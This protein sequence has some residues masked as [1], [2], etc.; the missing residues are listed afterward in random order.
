[1]SDHP[2]VVVSE[3]NSAHPS[4]P[5][6]AVPMSETSLSS[7]A[8][9]VLAGP[10]ET[11]LSI[12][13]ALDEVLVLDKRIEKKTQEATFLAMFS[14]KN[15]Q[16]LVPNQFQHAAQADWQC[17]QDLIHRRNAIKSAIL[18]SNAN[19]Y[20][21]VAGER[22]T[23][24]EVIERKKSLIL[25]VQLLARMKS[26]R[27]SVLRAIETNNVQM[28]SELQKLLEIHFGKGGSSRTSSND[29][30]EISKSFRE[31]NSAKLLDP[32]GLDSK[33]KEIE[34]YIEQFQREIKFILSE[35]NAIT[36][37]TVR[38]NFSEKKAQKQQLQQQQ[39]L[40][41]QQGL[42]EEKQQA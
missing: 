5:G 4:S 31:N 15:R 38:A 30:E 7:A 14:K 21:T 18:G 28:D 6:S 24:A 8:Q 41:Q 2:F 1:M 11:V 17:I 9:P 16:T 40:L 10:G 39:Q 19:T 13:R 20:V 32:I 23:I 36:K 12:I 27:E 25:Q 33:I 22:L 3:P 29:V 37:I 35:S 34:Q 42:S 26:Q